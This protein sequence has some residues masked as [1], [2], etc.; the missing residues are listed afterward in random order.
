MRLICVS[1]TG[2]PI[3]KT[4]LLVKT[5]KAEV[6]AKRRGHLGRFGRT[7]RDHDVRDMRLNKTAPKMMEGC[8]IVRTRFGV[9]RIASWSKYPI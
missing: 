7:S 9:P 8:S 2:A 4:A 1:G 5:S 6:Q 3:A